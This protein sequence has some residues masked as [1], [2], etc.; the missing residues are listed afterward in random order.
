M[1]VHARIDET[2][3]GRISVGQTANF[4]VD[5]YRGRRFTGKVVQIRKSPEVIRNVVTYTVVIRT[6]N[7]ALLLLPGMTALIK[8]IVKRSEEQLLIPMAALRY[9]PGNADGSAESAKGP[10]GQARVW[11]LVDNVATPVQVKTG[12]SDARYTALAGG[13]LEAGDEVIVNEIVQQASREIFGIR[14]GF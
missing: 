13:P 5:A 8:I 1:E 4:T 6:R 3:I 14:F 9:V 10:D 7:D 12:D 11:K 2:D